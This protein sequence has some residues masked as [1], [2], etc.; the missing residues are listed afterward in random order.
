MQYIEIFIQLNLQLI[1]SKVS[2]I[3][4]FQD[5]AMEGQQINAQANIK[6]SAKEFSAKAKSKREVYILLTVD[7][8]AYLPKYETITIYFLKDLISGKK[9]CKYLFISADF[10]RYKMQ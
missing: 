1:S 7:V 8:K 2:N 9:R 6:I 3:E 5:Q 4:L 10:P